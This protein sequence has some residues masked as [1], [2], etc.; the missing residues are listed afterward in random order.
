MRLDMS[1]ESVT[2]MGLTGG[3]MAAGHG[4]IN[5]C[6]VNVKTGG[7]PIRKLF[8]CWSLFTLLLESPPFHRVRLPSFSA[9][10]G[11]LFRA[12]PQG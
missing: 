12:F 10:P 7:S 5:R 3:T 9:P 2:K 4:K 8:T 1:S 6:I 11:G